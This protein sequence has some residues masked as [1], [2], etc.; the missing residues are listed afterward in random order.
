M[1][2]G[3]LVYVKL[4]IFLMGVSIALP[5]LA[6]EI[7]NM[8]HEAPDAKDIIEALQPRAGGPKLKFRGLKVETKSVDARERDNPTIALSIIFEFNSA[9]LTAGAKQTLDQVGKA[10]TSNELET[11]RFMLEGHTDSVGSAEY[12]M[13][14]S[15]RRAR[16]VRAYLVSNFGISQKRLVAVGRGEKFPILPGNPTARDNRRVQVMNLGS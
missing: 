2:K 12:N 3:I 8:M 14:L 13:G 11:Y 4:L 7:K 16:V 5:A 10:L 9:E 6:G 15:Q 1:M